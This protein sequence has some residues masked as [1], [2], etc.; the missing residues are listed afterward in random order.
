[1]LEEA[2]AAPDRWTYSDIAIAPPQ[3]DEFE[4]LSLYHK[5]T[6]G[7]AALARKAR[8]PPLHIRPTSDLYVNKRNT[9]HLN[10]L[11]HPASSASSGV[12][13]HRLPPLSILIFP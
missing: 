12:Q 7:E 4:Q 13:N 3:Q 11:R 5:T 1:M 2:L 8:L 10:A 9:Y 6:A